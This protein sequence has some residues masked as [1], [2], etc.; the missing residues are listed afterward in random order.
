MRITFYGGAGGVTG[1][2]HL[3]EMGGLKILLDCGFFQG[4]RKEARELNMKLPFDPVSIDAVVLSHAHLDHCGMLP[5]MAKGGFK[6]NVYAT[7]GTRDV[8]E[9]IMKDAAHV[10][11]QDAEHLRRQKSVG[12]ALAEPFYTF[13]DIEEVLSRFIEVPYVRN[14][15][16]WFEMQGSVGGRQTPSSDGVSR[17]DVRLKFYDAGHI[18]GSAV[19][20]L[21]A[22]VDRTRNECL[23]YTGD[24]G[25]RGAPL[26]PD[27]EYV[28][29][30]ADVLLLEST[31][32]DRVHADFARAKERLKLIILETLAKQG[33]LIVPAFALGRT[34]E[35]L[36][37]LHRL[38]DE[39]EIPRIPIFV[40]SPLADRITEVYKNHTDDF[41]N[42]T[43]DEFGARGDE[44]LVF[45]NLTLVKTVE[46]SKQ[47]NDMPGPFLVIAGS[48]MC[49]HGRIQHHLTRAISDPR[50]TV[51]ITGFQAVDTL[52]RRLVEGERRVR[53]YDG[54]YDVRAR[55]E[56][57]NEL[58]AHAD[59]DE[60]LD[61]A[62][63]V[64][65]VKNIFLVH[66]E[67]AQATGLKTLL[68]ER[69]K[70]WKVLIPERGEM[71]EVER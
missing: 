41:D 69:R 10:Q 30:S 48:G 36:Y 56:K 12:S 54:F 60:L 44:P 31:Y 58:S 34:Q 3:V 70:E 51:L 65:G 32:G 15:G 62:E 46:E 26:I 16:E 53:I 47:L 55:I 2:K 68:E 42:E 71:V 39:K 27:P 63:H 35:L 11:M 17:T 6:G 21:E 13:D 7:A 24:L 45:R 4:H 25:R 1:S 40:D 22:P 50:N 59:R 18:L 14:M 64:K 19:T 9:W 52:G 28:H 61:Y 57:L 33:K 29:E 5:M 23:V 38:T 66:G 20:V 67:H 8:A 37:L 49:E 43:W